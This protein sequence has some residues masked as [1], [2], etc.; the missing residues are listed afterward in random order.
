MI[1]EGQSPSIFPLEVC[2]IDTWPERERW[3]I[4]R[5]GS[6]ARLTNGSIGGDGATGASLTEGARKK[7]SDK[8]R[9]KKKP[10]FTKEHIE[11]FRMAKLGRKL[12]PDQIAKISAANRGK[13]RSVEFCQRLSEMA[14]SR[15]FSHMHTAEA[16]GRARAANIG[17]KRTQETKRRMQLAQSKPVVC[18]ETGEVFESATFLLNKGIPCVNRAIR[19]GTRAGGFHWKYRDIEYTPP[20]R[21]ING[22][23][24]QC[25]ET[26]VIYKTIRLAAK[27]VGGSASAILQ[28]IRIGGRSSKLH[29]KYANNSING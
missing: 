19:R 13:K 18:V 6:T 16:R 3:W 1:R 22:R 14:K 20:P 24:V 11:K 27:S 26:G 8:N 15:D 7:I 9:G 17:Q 23:S 5:L 10:P 25:V 29:W 12:P 21:P 2:S 28:A 4:A